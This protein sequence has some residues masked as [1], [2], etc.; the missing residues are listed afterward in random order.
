MYI[1][2]HGTPRSIRL[3]QAK[4]LVGNQEKIICNRKNIEIIETTVTDYRAIGLVGFS[5]Q[6]R[7]DWHVSKKK[8]RL[9]T[10]SMCSMQER[11]LFTN[12]EYVNKK[13]QGLR[14]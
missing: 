3:D 13:Q 6:L 4:G 5:I 11:S 1:E 8:N 2:N 12:C 7:I 9:I 14:P 10:R